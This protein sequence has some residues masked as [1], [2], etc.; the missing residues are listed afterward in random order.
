MRSLSFNDVGVGRKGKGIEQRN[1]NHFVF[2]LPA[3]FLPPQSV[4]G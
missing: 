3:I 1:L 2:P 4:Q